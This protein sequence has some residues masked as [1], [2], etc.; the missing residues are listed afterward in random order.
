MLTTDHLL[1]VIDAFREAREVSDARVSALLFN[2]GKRVRLL[3]CGGDVG[4][5][6]LAASFQW[7]SDHWPAGGE[8]PADVPRPP[9]SEALV[10]ASAQP[11]A[12]AS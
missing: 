4:S 8:W 6:P 9:V 3:R 5:R 1:R 12:L 10:M 11:E 2:D 7:L